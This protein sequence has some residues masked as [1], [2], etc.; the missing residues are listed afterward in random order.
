MDIR[1]VRYSLIKTIEC[2][3]FFFNRSGSYEIE[4]IVDDVARGTSIRCYLR[5]D[6]AEFSKEETIKRR[7][8]SCTSPRSHIVIR[9]F[10]LEIVK[11]YSNF[12]AAPIF[13]NDT[14]VNNLRVCLSIDEFS[15]F[16]TLF[17]SRRYG[18]KMENRLQKM[19]IQNSIVLLPVNMINLVIHCN[20]KS[21]YQSIYE[22]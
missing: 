19:N 7:K 16:N 18:W 9:L 8:H 6:C 21:M 3:W 1:W 10:R 11:K 4:P 5:D 14:R 17:C 13:I 15:L 12:V 22:H 20:I 2:C